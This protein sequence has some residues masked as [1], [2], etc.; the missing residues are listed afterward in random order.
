MQTERSPRH[1]RTAFFTLV[2][3]NLL[4]LA[5]TQQA[6]PGE[7]HEPQRLQM[8]LEADKVRLVDGALPE[9]EKAAT[10]ELVTACQLYSGIPAGPARTLQGALEQERSPI[11]LVMPTA[12]SM[13][14]WVHIPPLAN[15]AAA[16]K[17]L[18]ELKQLG[19]DDATPMLDVGPQQFAISLGLFRNEQLASKYLEA[20]SKKGVRSA[21]LESK[22]R[23]VIGDQ[24]KIEIEL[25]GPEENLR[26][27]V[28]SNELFATLTPSDCKSP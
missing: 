25:S 2:L 17:K 1:I 11:K 4:F 24:E 16:D 12:K 23:G 5:W 19:V 18:A 21:R 9:T 10:P 22:E 3:A 8:Q 15:K 27:L 13:L 20:L 26:T 28:S 7:G 6:G 14:Y